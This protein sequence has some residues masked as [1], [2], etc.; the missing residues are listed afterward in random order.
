MWIKGEL[1]LEAELWLAEQK[2][3]VVLA[4]PHPLFGGDMWFPL[5]GVLAKRAHEKKL[6][7][8]RFNFRGVGASEGSY[9]GGP[10]EVQDFNATVKHLLDIGVKKVVP[11]GYSFGA[12]IVMKWIEGKKFDGRW[13]VVAPPVNFM[14]HPSQRGLSG[15]GL[16][17][18]GTKDNF[19]PAS[20][21][22]REYDRY[23]FI[24][25]DGAD[26]MFS[27]FE[28]LVADKVLEFLESN[29]E[30]KDA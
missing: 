30:G 7:A 14:K 18:C 17:I 4:H 23:R 8:L 20:K 15:E 12:C 28:E 21:V 10:G 22:A 16:V 11:I 25:V 24:E 29:G 6:T 27:G 19:S 9:S 5:L 3:G 1:N 13:V 26:H 2:L